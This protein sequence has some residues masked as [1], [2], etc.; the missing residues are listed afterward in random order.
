MATKTVLLVFLW[1]A[2]QLQGTSAVGAWLTAAAGSGKAFNRTSSW[3]YG[4]ISLDGPSKWKTKFA[5]C[6]DGQQS[7]VELSYRGA[8]YAPLP[9]LTFSNWE[10]V[11]HTQTVVNNG[12][13]VQVSLH[14]EK[15]QTLSGGGLPGLFIFAQYHFHWGSDDAKGS[16]HT[17]DRVRFPLELHLVFYNSRYESPLGLKEATKHKD[18]LAVLTVLFLQT[19]K[20]NSALAPVV[21][22]LRDIQRPI[23]K[24]TILGGSPLA[25]LLPH[26]TRRFFRY[27]GSLTTPTCDDAVTWTILDHAMPVSHAQLLAFRALQNDRGEKLLD[28][29]RPTQPLNGRKVVRNFH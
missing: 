19:K 22:H 5:L 8:K 2:S 17:I 1:G 24:V 23:S 12:H 29:Y 28:N 11:P 16:E 10:Q 15:N 27:H 6:G 14:P 18:G 13:T 4:S 25:A 9:H 21:K 3:S 26:N 7:P 20:D